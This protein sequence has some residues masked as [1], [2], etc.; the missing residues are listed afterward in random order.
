M[1]NALRRLA[2]RFRRTD[3]NREDAAH[4]PQSVTSVTEHA[5]G[6]AY[7]PDPPPGYVKSYDEGRPPS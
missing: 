7:L 5:K 6:R 2:A 4:D 1:I 3:A